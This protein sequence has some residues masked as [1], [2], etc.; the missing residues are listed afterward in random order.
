M[1]LSAGSAASDL[2]GKIQE[3]LGR[4]SDAA[5]L[6]EALYAG[7]AAPGE[8]PNPERMA[9]DVRDALA[10]IADKPKE[11][12]KIRVRAGSSDATIEI[13]N[14]DMPFLV[15]SIMGEMQARGLTVE[16]LLHPLLRTR[17]S[18]AGRLEAIL[19]PGDTGAGDGR[20]E[21]FILL[22]VRGLPEGAGRELE[23]ALSA[24]LD[25]V[26]IAV[27]DWSAM[28]SRVGAAIQ[29]FER[30]PPEAPAELVSETIAFLK[31]LVDGHFTFL[32]VRDLELSGSPDTGDLTTVEGSGLGLLRNPDIQVLRRRTEFVS[33]TPEIRRFFFG[34]SPLIIT[35]AN[36]VSRVHRRVHM[37]YIGIKTYGA[38]RK[39]PAGEIRIVG[40]FT[41]QAYTQSPRQ[42][43]FL[44]HKV[45]TVL[46][47]SGHPPESHDGKA[48]VNILETFPRD[49]LFQIGVRQLGEWVE[50]ILALDLR[51]RVRVFA[52][53]DRFERF[54]SLLVYAPRERYNSSVRERIGALLARAY[55]GRVSADYPFFPDGPLVRV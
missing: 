51:P 18:P 48:I 19:S 42:I 10:F 52:R 22:R 1:A 37:D 34:P 47:N 15:D 30:E 46:A 43:P 12:H 20:R 29:R 16:T 27:S 5:R 26:R 4:R 54:V 25:D 35:K 36:V 21:S 44:R 40:L 14:D 11:R 53:M 2:F 7:G 23:S 32:G 33:M 41:S 24:L 38:D 6:A 28:A 55:N 17:R 13:L 39:T 8:R 50:G 45:E 31:W 49:E 9:A 3:L